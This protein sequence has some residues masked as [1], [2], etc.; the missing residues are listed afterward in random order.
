MAKLHAQSP[1]AIGTDP[2]V[3]GS[4]PLRRLARPRHG[5]QAPGGTDRLEQLAEGV[6]MAVHHVQHPAISRLQRPF[7]GGDSILT[8]DPVAVSPPIPRPCA[9]GQPGQACRQVTAG[10]MQRPESQH[11]HLQRKRTGAAARPLQQ[12]VF[13]LA[14]HLAMGI[15]GAGGGALIHPAPARIAVDAAAA[16]VE[17]LPQ[18]RQTVEQRHQRAAGVEIGGG[19]GACLHLP[20]PHRSDGEHHGLGLLQ[21]TGHRHC[22]LSQ[23]HPGLPA[24][25]L[26]V[27]QPLRARG[28]EQ[29]LVTGLPVLGQR[30]A[31]PT[32]TDD[33][34]AHGEPFPDGP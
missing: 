21:D 23:H 25:T 20:I 30:H 26:Q 34:D 7:D 28:G 27:R 33:G 9:A 16:G 1:Q 18:A 2:P 5:L 22:I 8:V 3:G 11:R 12:Q 4:R 10:A 19:I 14:K 32:A 31:Q 15:A 29:K 13:S 17:D 6:R 24:E